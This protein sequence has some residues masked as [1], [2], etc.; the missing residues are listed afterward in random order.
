MVFMNSVN[1]NLIQIEEFEPY[2]IQEGVF[3]ATYNKNG[4]SL[5]LRMELLTEANAKS[6]TQFKTMTC[7]VANQNSRGV[8]S[9]LVSLAGNINY[10]KH[11][12]MKEVTGF[13]E[14]EYISF[15]EKRQ[16]A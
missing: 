16:L 1:N 8:L 9:G 10:P 11:E 12:K 2:V 14:E 13:T 15:T 7:K 6:W 4:E 5:F 3:G